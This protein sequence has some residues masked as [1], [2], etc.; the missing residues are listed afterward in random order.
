MDN[1]TTTKINTLQHQLEQLK[2]RRYGCEL[3]V[4]DFSTPTGNSAADQSLRVD[5]EVAQN[6]IVML[7]RQIATR[8]AALDELKAQITQPAPAQTGIPATV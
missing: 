6:T 3:Q 7:D 4:A 5:A 8:E 1:L 2:V